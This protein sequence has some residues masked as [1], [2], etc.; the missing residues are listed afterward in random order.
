MKEKY[1]TY[2][3]LNQTDEQQIRS[4]FVSHNTLSKLL[5][6]PPIVKSERKPASAINWMSCS[7]TNYSNDEFNIYC[8]GKLVVWWALS[9]G[10]V[11]KRSEIYCT[12][13]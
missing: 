13:K 2:S 4:L 12:S 5:S 8:T 11:Y 9:D 6:L 10:A 1:S 7:N 3:L